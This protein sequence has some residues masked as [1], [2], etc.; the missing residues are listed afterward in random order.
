MCNK[1]LLTFISVYHQSVKPVMFPACICIIFIWYKVF[2]MKIALW[3]S[4]GS[5]CQEKI[6]CQRKQ[7]LGAGN[8][9]TLALQAIIYV[10]IAITKLTT[11]TAF[12]S[13]MVIINSLAPRSQLG[14]VNGV[15][16]TMAALGRS[17]GPILG[18]CFGGSQPLC[19]FLAIIS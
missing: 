4:L 15:R 17:S 6:S 12:T 19:T 10:A 13:S 2:Y 8:K 9:H 3:L 11:Q 18:G 7:M 16:M 5:H 14:S 1:S